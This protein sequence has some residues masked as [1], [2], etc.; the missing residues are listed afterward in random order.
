MDVYGLIGRPVSHS[1]SPPLHEA[2]YEQLGLDARYVTFEPTGDA[3]DAIRAA[4]RLGVAGLNVTV[5]FKE[6]VVEHVTLAGYAQEIG[7]VNTVVFRD[8]GP[9]GY[10]TDAVGFRRALDHH[11]VSPGGQRAVLVGAGGAARAIATALAD[12]GAII[13]IYNRTAERAAELAEAVGA[14]QWGGLDEAGLRAACRRGDLLINATS[15]GL[16]E[17]RSP[18][19]AAALTE[20]LVVFDAVYRPLKTRL[21]KEAAAVGAEPIDGG[22][23]LLYQGAAAFEHWTGREAPIEAMNEALRA[24]L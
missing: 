12:D 19:P 5:P 20:E 23:M 7:A 1:L 2:A 16:E 21:L 24:R 4:Q 22:W 11:G 13:E 3:G 10:N 15:V 18:V 14:A 17:D 9:V 8:D 6:T